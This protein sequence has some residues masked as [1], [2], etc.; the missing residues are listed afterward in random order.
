MRKAKAA[1][2][3]G[4]G[5][6]LEE[7]QQEAVDEFLQFVGTLPAD[8]TIGVNLTRVPHKYTPDLMEAEH[9][10]PPEFRPDL[11]EMMEEVR[12]RYGPGKYRLYIRHTDPLTRKRKMVRP[13]FLLGKD[14]R[15]VPLEAELAG[16]PGPDPIRAAMDRLSSAA[17]LQAEASELRALQDAV[18]GKA[19]G[20][21][22]ADP[23]EQT[24]KMIEIVKSAVPN[25][26]LVKL[27]LERAAPAASETPK[28]SEMLA[29]AR[30]FITLSREFGGG[31]GGGQSAW[32]E[33]VLGLVKELGPYLPAI[34]AALRHTTDRGAPVPAAPAEP[35]PA[36]VP[37]PPQVPP[38]AAAPALESPA[39]VPGGIQWATLLRA[40][41]GDALKADRLRSAL[42]A[43][44][45]EMGAPEETWPDGWDRTIDFCEAHLP[46][47]L[48][49]LLELEPARVWEAWV[50]WLPAHQGNPRA[51]GWVDGLLDRAKMPAGGPQ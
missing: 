22:A 29:T 50:T 14:P 21:P 1:P 43:A 24:R 16:A 40:V 47:F 9:L 4:A 6:P 35:S 51:R 15:A 23:V 10:A 27:L 2:A 37:G 39:P 44:M 41:N 25:V 30:E 31:T 19:A 32:A 26:D 45:V 38:P 5:A 34:A 8:S 7:V 46:G 36:P 28:F 11:Q 3:D 42:L 48:G 18:A 13:V 33:L 17:Q 49:S 20:P 12:E